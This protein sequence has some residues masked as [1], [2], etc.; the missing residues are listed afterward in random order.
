MFWKNNLKD[1]D[2]GWRSASIVAIDPFSS[3]QA[4][5]A[6]V[7]ANRVL[8]GAGPSQMRVPNPSRFSKGVN[9]RPKPSRSARVPHLSRPLRK[10]GFHEPQ[11]Q[12]FD[13]PT[14]TDFN[15]AR[16]RPYNPERSEEPALSLSQEPMHF[17]RAATGMGTPPQPGRA[18]LQSCREVAN[19][20]ALQRLR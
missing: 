15:P 3:A 19:V 16:Y 13:F 8:Q 4:L 14:G 11:S 1:S 20:S 10:V 2:F 9:H 6:E 18:R 7:P 17:A 12:G 5:A